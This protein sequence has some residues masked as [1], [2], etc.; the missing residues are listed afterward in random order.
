MLLAE[1][2]AL[3][4]EYLP[5]EGVHGGRR[6]REKEKLLILQA[7]ISPSFLEDGR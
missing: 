4:V 1:A 7:R 5:R 6:E 3:T 2:V